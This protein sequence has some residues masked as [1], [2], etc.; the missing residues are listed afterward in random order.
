MRALAGGERKVVVSGGRAPCYLPTTGH[1]LYVL[2][3]DLFGIA[4]DPERLVT[5]RNPVSL[6]HG[7]RLAVGACMAN[8]SVAR[9]GT[10]LYLPGAVENRITVWVD[11]QGKEEPLKLGPGNYLSVRLSP[12]GTKLV[13]SEETRGERGFVVWNLAAETR[14]R[15]TQTSGPVGTRPLWTPDGLRI[16][17]GGTDGQ[18]MVKPA[19]NTRTPEVFVKTAEQR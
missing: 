11:R 15:L 7:V 18:L 2:D 10:L 17:Y 12:D 14:T 9:D 19:N 13:M 4:F 8:Y 16:V 1:L 3:S 6:V 5:I